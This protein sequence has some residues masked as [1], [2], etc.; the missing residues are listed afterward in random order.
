MFERFTDRARRVV[1]LA[2][3]E[4]RMLNHNYIGTEHI[5]L[6]L[7][8]EG[9]GVAAKALESLGMSLAAVRQQVEEITG[10]G[11][12][13]PSGH[14][15]FTAR[16]KKTLELSRQE[17]A[18]LGSTHIGTEHILLGLIREGEGIAAQVLVRRGANLDRVRQHV[19][20][21]LPGWQGQ[22]PAPAGE[23][24][25][26]RASSGAREHAVGEGGLVG[27]LASIGARLTAIE[28][29]LGI[30]GQPRPGRYDQQI[31]EF[32]EAKEAAINS[33]DFKQA[34][35]L[36]DQEKRLIER[37]E[38]TAGEHE[39]PG[40]GV[41]SVPEEAARLRAEVARLQELLRRHGIDPGGDQGDRAA[42]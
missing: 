25:P 35:A 18:E 30:S 28:R 20:G 27:A 22:E 31:A 5:L 6:G 11:Q 4:A 8:H 32:R 14:I 37:N 26:L 42:D 10:Q 12:Q 16:A 1:V 33:G 39:P 41:L 2:Q 40:P 29:R 38:A 34:A 17:S 24:S 13:A 21:L 7:I 19:I 9:E 15:P 36:R 3:E 23:P